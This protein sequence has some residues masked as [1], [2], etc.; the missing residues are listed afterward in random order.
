M[1]AGSI[2]L[3]LQEFASGDKTALDRLMPHV[4]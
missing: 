1:A 3:I 2:T 4:Y